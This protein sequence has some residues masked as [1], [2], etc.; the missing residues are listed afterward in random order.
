MM[1]LHPKVLAVLSDTEYGDYNVPRT[2]FNF[3]PDSQPTNEQRQLFE[4]YRNLVRI[5]FPM[6]DTWVDQIENSPAEPGKSSRMM[7][8]E[9]IPY[10]SEVIAQDG[11]Y[12][13]KKFPNHNISR[14]LLQIMPQSYTH[15]AEEFLVTAEHDRVSREISRHDGEQHRQMVAQSL[16]RLDTKIEAIESNVVALS[17]QVEDVGLATR[18]EF[19]HVK[20]A[21]GIITSGRGR[22]ANSALGT[23][24]LTNV[25]N[26][27]QGRG[28]GG[29]G[30]RGG[31]GGTGGAV[32][33]AG[34]FPGRVSAGRG[35]VSAPQPPSVNDVLLNQER[36]AV[37]PT[38]M[39]QT[40]TSIVAVWNEFNLDGFEKGRRAKTG[41]DDALR[42]RYSRWL[43]IIQKV[44]ERARNYYGGTS[45]EGMKRAA[46]A[47][48]LD[49]TNAGKTVPQ[50]Y[51]EWKSND[52]STRK[53]KSS[54]E[55]TNARN[56]GGRGRRRYVAV[57]CFDVLIS[58]VILSSSSHLVLHLPHR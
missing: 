4:P 37:V 35:G 30:G 34:R 2:K 38:K 12:F 19:Q 53:R 17:S 26:N 58:T 45:V 52:P 21:M 31:G 29:S 16:Q 48:D 1:E 20:N 54:S 40:I 43:Y 5:L 25:A 44:E 33:T 39:P 28:R 7:V 15:I 14:L 57:L 47:L 22:G 3:D 50:M 11:C 32:V 24:L 55:P 13:L 49:R 51:E 6:Y 8:Y 42:T 10:F 41:W 18:L 46:A 9:V 56:R 27:L 23:Q 36:V